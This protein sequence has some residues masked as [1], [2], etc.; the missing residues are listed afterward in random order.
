M[1]SIDYGELHRVVKLAEVL[2]LIGY[3]PAWTCMNESRGPCPVHC[4]PDQRC[5]FINLNFGSWRCHRCKRGGGAL[6]LFMTVRGLDVR[7]AA[8]LLCEL[9]SKP[10]PYK[11]SSN[12]RR[13]RA[14]RNRRKP[15]AAEEQDVLE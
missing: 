2:D 14:P 12:M 7:P 6:N 10:V 11:S 13:P 3:K 8:R 1:S 5:C 9:L 15:F 4:H